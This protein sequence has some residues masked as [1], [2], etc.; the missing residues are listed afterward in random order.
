[1]G[2]P[3][4]QYFS[5]GLTEEITSRLAAVA[6]LG[7]IARTSADQYRNTTKALRQIGQELGAGYVLEGSDRWEQAGGKSRMRVTPH[8]IQVA[9]DRHLWADRYDADLADV[10]QI[11][12]QIAEQVTSALNVALA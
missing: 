3:E 7:V 6:G 4:D 12:G 1:M 8:L 9:D 2:A 10:F 11:Q 5:D